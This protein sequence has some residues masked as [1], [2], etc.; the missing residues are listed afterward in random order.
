MKMFKLV[1]DKVSTAPSPSTG[2]EGAEA[3]APHPLA[4]G[5]PLKRKVLRVL[6]NQVREIEDRAEPGEGK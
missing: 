1:H 6:E 4:D 5:E 2:R 3:R